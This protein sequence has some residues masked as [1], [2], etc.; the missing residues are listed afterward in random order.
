MKTFFTIQNLA[1]GPP[2]KPTVKIIIL[3]KLWVYVSK[4]KS[5][6]IKCSALLGSELSKLGRAG[7]K[8]PLK[9]FDLTPQI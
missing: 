3:V 7:D 8:K 5:D 4:F 9:K 6:F 2:T 1:L